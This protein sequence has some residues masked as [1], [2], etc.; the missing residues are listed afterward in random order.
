M[1]H[2][3]LVRPSL[4]AYRQPRAKPS[5][6]GARRSEP[7][8]EAAGPFPAPPAL[9]NA[10]AFYYVKQ[11]NA[12][13]PMVVVLDGQEEVLGQI[14]WYDHL[15]VSLRRP[16]GSD[17]LLYKKAVKYMY[18]LEEVDAARAERYPND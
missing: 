11:M 9:T 17:V 18:K 5:G 15:C 13:T 14:Q 4:S 7:A 6:Y 12:A 1:E 10:E 3:K 16:D 2:R 8:P